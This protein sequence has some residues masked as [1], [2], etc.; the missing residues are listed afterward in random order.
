M[1]N[2]EHKTGEKMILIIRILFNCI[3]VLIFFGIPLFLSAG[4]F[5]FW[6]AWLFLGL[7]DVCFFLI[8]IYFAFKNP[9]FAKKR[10]QGEEVEKPQKL[11]MSLLILST[12]ITLSLAG[13]NYRFHWSTVPQLYIFIFT[14]IIIGGF[15]MLF[16]VMKQNSYASRVIEIQEEQKLIETGMYS[17]VRHPMYLAFSII[18]CSSPVIL[19]SLYTLIPAFCIPFLVTFRINN[20]EIVL[21]NGL[22]GYDLYMSKVKYRLMPFIW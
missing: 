11:V 5:K 2:I 18:I 12:L 14:I 4:T 15:V 6:N 1:Q 10:L 9:E 7:F 17:I 8:L 22:K 16:V 13:F 3:L 20:E 21:K 19:G